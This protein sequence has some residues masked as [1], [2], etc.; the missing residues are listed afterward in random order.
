ML[1]TGWANWA[2]WQY[3]GTGTVS[4]IASPDTDLDQASATFLGLLNPGTQDQSDGA[5]RL[6]SSCGRPSRPRARR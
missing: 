4:G 1:P 5:R 3:S 6:A 2:I